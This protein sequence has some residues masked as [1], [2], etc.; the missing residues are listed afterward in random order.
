MTKLQRYRAPAN[1]SD[2]QPWDIQDNEPFIWF[3]RFEQFRLLGPRRT[4]QALWNSLPAPRGIN[5]SPHWTKSAREWNWYQRAAAW[6]LQVLTDKRRQFSDEAEADKQ[7]RI[8]IIKAARNKLVQALNTLDPT[9]AKFSEVFNALKIVMDE[10]R[11]EYD[12]QPTQ[13]HK[14]SESEADLA[15]A[16]AL[17]KLASRRQDAAAPE[18]AAGTGYPFLD[19]RATVVDEEL[20]G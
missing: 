16:D 2:R 1:D 11:N 8:Q 5:V 15:I 20:Q 12:D 3:A 10:L 7:T 14:L 6:D 9:T 13:R 17:E 18:D 4:M 19:L